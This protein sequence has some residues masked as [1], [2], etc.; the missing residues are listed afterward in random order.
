MLNN[1]SSEAVRHLIEVLIND[2]ANLQDR[3][4]MLEEKH[5]FTEDEE[6]RINFAYT[7]ESL[8]N[9]M[10]FSSHPFP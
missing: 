6:N 5:N 2:K 10:D 1:L 3:I 9:V 7:P 4:R 8:S